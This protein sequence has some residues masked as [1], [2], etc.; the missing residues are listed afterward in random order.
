VQGYDDG[1]IL[2]DSCGR[3]YNEIAYEKHL[4]FCQRKDKENKMKAKLNTKNNQQVGRTNFN[5]K[6]NKK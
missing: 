2:C 5:N 6:F 4:N 1:L 3:R